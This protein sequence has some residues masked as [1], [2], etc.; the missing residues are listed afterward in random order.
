EAV[1]VAADGDGDQAGAGVEATELVVAD[2]VG[3]GSAARG[4]GE[5]GH[6]VAGNPERGVRAGCTRA[7]AAARVVPVGPDTGR[8]RVPERHVVDR[9]GRGGRL[10]GG[11]GHD[12]GRRAE[13]C[14]QGEGEG[15][16]F[17][18]A[19]SRN[20]G[21]ATQSALVLRIVTEE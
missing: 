2:V 9:A 4:E 17:H 19:T 21:E 6:G 15:A 18:D 8:V 5:A 10:G 11:G 16:D 14:G 20:E 13:Q 3:G 7:G 1:I 12:D